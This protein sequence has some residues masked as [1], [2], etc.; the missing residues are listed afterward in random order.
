MGEERMPPIRFV[1]S[2]QKGQSGLDLLLGLLALLIVLT[3]LS[4]VLDSFDS[5][6]REITLHQQ[7]RENGNTVSYFLA[8][9]SSFFRETVPY[10]V[11]STGTSSEDLPTI[12]NSLVRSTGSTPISSLYALKTPQ[13]FSCDPV[14][15]WSLSDSNPDQLTLSIPASETL[16]ADDLSYVSSFDAPEEYENKHAFTFNECYGPFSVG[17]LP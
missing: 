10:P 8:S 15:G 17:A 11:G 1:G 16:L 6:H 14:F 7:L 3:A 4:P 12:T 9:S 2:F 5:T 13:G